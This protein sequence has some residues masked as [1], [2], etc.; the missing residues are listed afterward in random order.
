MNTRHI[1]VACAIIERD[2]QVLAAQRSASMSLPLKWEFPG[3]KIDP[4]E[5][6]EQCLRRELVEELDVVISVGP[7]LAPTTHRYPA[8]T[9]TLYPFI[10][11]IAE[12]EITL[13]EHAAIA[14]LPPE[15]LL[16]LDWAEADAPILAE[17][18]RS[19]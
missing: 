15:D 18:T 17:Y 6:P 11:S 3:G 13:A 14:W 2:G 10:C 9:V 4:G 8:F 5:T 1:H 16:T 19:P 7:A 12:G